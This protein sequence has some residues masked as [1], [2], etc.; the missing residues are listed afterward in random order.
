MDESKEI[1]HDLESSAST[2]TTGRSANQDTESTIPEGT[3]INPSDQEKAA[4]NTSSEGLG[5]AAIGETLTIKKRVLPKGDPVPSVIDPTSSD[6]TTFKMPEHSS[7]QPV[8][9]VPPGAAET[10]ASRAFNKANERDQTKD[11][12]K[13][14]DIE[15]TVSHIPGAFP[16]D[17]HPTPIEETAGA[18]A[19]GSTRATDTGSRPYGSGISAG[20]SAQD[21]SVPA[22]STLTTT[23]SPSTRDTGYGQAEGTKVPDRATTSTI[24]TST[25]ADNASSQPESSG[26]FDRILGAVG[27]GGTAAAISSA[28]PGTGEEK[29]SRSV[30][31]YP[32]Q[33]TTTTGVDSYT[34]PTRSGDVADKPATTTGVDS[35]NAPTRS[36]N[37]W[38]QPTTTTGVDTYTTP[39]HSSGVSERLGA[40]TGAA[41]S[42][43]RTPSGPTPSHYRKES[44]PT[45]AYPQGQDSPAP[46]NP[47]VGGTA[48]AADE[49][50]RQDHGGH[51]GGLAAAG[52]GIGLA[53]GGVAAH[54]YEHGRS[55]PE[56]HGRS[57]HEEYGRSQPSGSATFYSLTTSDTPSQPAQPT[58]SLSRPIQEDT[59]GYEAYKHPSNISPQPYASTDPQKDSTGYG[60]AATT[61]G[62]GVGAGTA[63]AAIHDYQDSGRQSAGA[64]PYRNA[65]AA[66][67]STA[68]SDVPFAS[69]QHAQ[70]LS[71]DIDE[72]P[73]ARSG[74]SQTPTDLRQPI[75]AEHTDDSRGYGRTAAAAGVGAGVGA[76]GAYALQHKDEPETGDLSGGKAYPT[77]QTT[78][79]DQPMV[80]TEPAAV[81]EPV[82]S[83]G[84]RTAQ[85][86]PVA[87]AATHQDPRRSNEGTD[88][89][90][91][92]PATTSYNE[93]ARD[94]T[95]TKPTPGAVQSSEKST[96]TEQVLKP[97]KEDRH[98]G[99]DAALAGA[100]GA[101]A[102][103]YGAHEY[104]EHQAEQEAARAAEAKRQ[105]DIA[106]QE[107]ARRR[108]FEKDQ[109]AA[110][111]RA[112]KEEKA[113]K[114]HEKAVEK[115]QKQHEKDLA[116]E[117]KEERKHQ[118]E[119]AKEEKK[120]EKEL[121]KEQKE[122][123]KAAAAAAL[124]EKE[125]RQQYE[126]EERERFEAAE[127]ERKRREKEAAGA[128]AI[129]TGA[130][131]GTAAYAAHDKE[132]Q[133][134]E[135]TPRSSRET[136]R[137]RL[138]KDPPQ[139]KKPGILKRIFKRRK[140]KDTGLEEEYSTD[141]E[142]EPRHSSHSG[143][144]GAAV[145][146]G[147]GVG[148]ATAAAAA[149]E[150][151]RDE[152]AAGEGILPQK[153]SYN[154]LHKD[155]TI[156]L[157]S[158]D[159]PIA[160]NLASER[161]AHQASG[162]TGRTATGVNEPVSSSTGTY[163]AGT[164]SGTGYDTGP[165][166]A[167][168]AAAATVPG[169]AGHDTTARDYGNTT[170]TTTTTGL[171]YDP[172]HDPEASRHLQEV[173]QQAHQ[174]HGEHHQGGFLHRVIDQLKPLP[175]PDEIAREHGH[176]PTHTTTTH[177]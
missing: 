42:T 151:H 61:A 138:H 163:P 112:A 169:S 150:H 74:F 165:T 159:T 36:G 111:K 134:G 132:Q 35:Y 77:S 103:A 102:A 65:P 2:G 8:A 58:S 175:E 108:Q 119:L 85:Q 115:E 70:G 106:E 28:L 56:E 75:T 98:T 167:D 52:A 128:A 139:E 45:T 4:E 148:A 62:L 50:D 154:P 177:D 170:G 15:Q 123:E 7:Y 26:T 76:A 12:V 93:P 145:G 71:R 63:A 40:A 126:R 146:A 9:G 90:G 49:E 127:A 143:R 31:D 96:K 135:T 99:R 116:K 156:P 155:E 104:N 172:K 113:E 136:D 51:R 64:L 41:A 68:S 152:G 80:A 79:E 129:G 82:P 55:Q 162:T 84:D 101:G 54:E 10:A 118:K 137:N 160:D 72:N 133:P 19:T 114:K 66:S 38:N 164:H 91:P 20:P 5:V 43:G 6:P 141:E 30:S 69:S 33:P 78:V 21:T 97:E 18:T 32:E 153:P 121:E 57:Q 168:T 176:E 16:T 95:T 140:N 17:E 147:A 39:L 73:A 157:V 34:A 22:P 149:H 124:A 37:D 11:T 27:L 109:K 161:Q 171:P 125:R 24:P 29:E 1:R 87:A 88:R 122:K 120:Q 13:D 92:V 110:E 44:I 94:S 23:A 89:G 174:Q 14:K 67:Q 46:I 3:G 86:V 117:E 173:E 100:A 83:A 130:A 131:A 53:A 48:V 81:P 25:S 142:E 47:P 60:A 166:A 59:S 158:T 107:E 105:Q 144:T